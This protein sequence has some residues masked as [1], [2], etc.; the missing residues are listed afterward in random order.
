MCEST[1]TF[2]LLFIQFFLPVLKHYT[3][4]PWKSAI[5]GMLYS[6]KGDKE[7]QKKAHKIAHDITVKNMKKF[8]AANPVR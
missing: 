5:T 7:A 6:A 3:L 8:E 1:A 4:Q 2:L